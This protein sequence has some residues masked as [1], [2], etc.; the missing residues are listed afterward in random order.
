MEESQRAHTLNEA[1]K[2][3]QKFMEDVMAL[4]VGQERID[5]LRSV[6]PTTSRKLA[7]HKIRNGILQANGGKP[8]KMA[9]PK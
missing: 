3:S 6:D 5:F 2:A 1:A 8:P 4:P 7:V 9:S